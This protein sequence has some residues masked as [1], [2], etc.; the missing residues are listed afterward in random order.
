MTDR[1]THSQPNVHSSVFPYHAMLITAVAAVNFVLDFVS[2][3]LLCGFLKDITYIACN[4]YI[5]Y[6]DLCSRARKEYDRLCRQR[7]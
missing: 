4:V 6:N 3:T 7:L 5:P 1:E 2:M